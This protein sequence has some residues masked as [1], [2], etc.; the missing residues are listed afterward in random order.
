MSH[1]C[2]GSLA[3]IDNGSLMLKMRSYIPKRSVRERECTH[4][5]EHVRLRITRETGKHPDWL[6]LLSRPISVQ[7]AWAFV[8]F[9]S[10]HAVQERHARGRVAQNMKIQNEK[11]GLLEMRR[12]KGL[13][14]MN[15]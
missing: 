5:T 11:K 4:E 3:H 1:R 7:C 13:P 15:Y 10:K 8:S 9:P 12:K 2:S 14:E 6:A